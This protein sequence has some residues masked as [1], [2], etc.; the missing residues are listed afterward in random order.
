MKMDKEQFLKTEFGQEMCDC[1][2]AWDV[3]LDR[4]RDWG[5]DTRDLEDALDN[6]TWCQAK[7]QVFQLALRQF[8]GMEYHFTRTE[9]HYG[10]VT[11]DGEERLFWKKRPRRG[12]AGKGKE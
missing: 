6:A 8:Y 5:L 11:E 4:T 7:W 9:T 2:T 10:I 1:V 3:A 12:R